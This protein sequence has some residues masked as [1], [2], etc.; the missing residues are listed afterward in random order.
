MYYRKIRQAL[1][2]YGYNQIPQM[3]SLKKQEQ[4][5]CRTVHK[6]FSAF[7]NV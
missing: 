5:E 4:W 1:E 3:P 2:K 6:Q 7:Y